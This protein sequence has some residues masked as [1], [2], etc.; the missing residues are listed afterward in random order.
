MKKGFTLAELIGV[1][2]VLALISLI[3]VPVVSKILKQNRKTLCETQMNNIIAAAKTWG[4]DNILTL[5]DNTEVT[6]ET[7]INSGYINGDIENPVL[8]E[9]IDPDNEENK[10]IITKNGNKYTYELNSAS[11]DFSC[12]I[13]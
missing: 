7:L 3:T 6:L 5:S 12:E 1:I 8:K 9:K 2:V 10:V 4:A 11:N 13:K